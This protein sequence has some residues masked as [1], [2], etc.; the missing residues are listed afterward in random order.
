M[1]GLQALNEFN[2]GINE[3]YSPADRVYYTLERH[4]SAFGLP[5][6]MIE[7]RND[8]ITTPQKNRRGAHAVR[9]LRENV[10]QSLSKTSGL[11][12]EGDGISKLRS[13]AL[14]GI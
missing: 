6:V 10:E 14:A 9:L 13:N 11:T 5:A 4:A 7:I 3:P 1:P 2:V 8:L 12:K